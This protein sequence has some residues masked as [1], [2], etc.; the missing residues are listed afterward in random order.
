MAGLIGVDELSGR[1]MKMRNKPPMRQS[2]ARFLNEGGTRL[3]EG[4]GVA[5][6][7]EFMAQGIAEVTRI[8]DMS[9]QDYWREKFVRLGT[10]FREREAHNVLFMAEKV[11]DL[12]GGWVDT[13][14]DSRVR[15]RAMV[16]YEH[17]LTIYVPF[18]AYKYPLSFA[19]PTDIE[20]G[21]WADR[22][23]EACRA[24]LA[25]RDRGLG[26]LRVLLLSVEGGWEEGTC[27]EVT[28]GGYSV[29]SAAVDSLPVEVSEI[30]VIHNNPNACVKISIWEERSVNRGLLVKSIEFHCP[31]YEI[32]RL[33]SKVITYEAS[34]DN[35]G[36]D[37]GASG[38]QKVKVLIAKD[39]ED[40]R[41][42]SRYFLPAQGSECGWP[43]DITLGQIADGRLEPS[44]RRIGEDLTIAQGVGR[45]IL[46]VSYFERPLVSLLWFLGLSFW[47]LYLLEY[48][49]SIIFG[50]G[51]LFLVKRHPLFEG[52]RASWAGWGLSLWPVESNK[53]EGRVKAVEGMD[54][55]ESE[56]R[57]FIFADFSPEHLFLWDPPQWSTPLLNNVGEAEML[58]CKGP[59]TI[60]SDGSYWSWQVAV[61]AG[62]DEN[63]YQY[64]MGFGGA[65]SWLKECDAWCY[66]RRRVFRGTKVRSAEMAQLKGKDA[67]VELLA[68]PPPGPSVDTVSPG[69]SPSPVM[70]VPSSAVLTPWEAV[71]SRV[72]QNVEEV[73]FAV[74]TVCVAFEKMK[75]LFT[76]KCP[77]ASSMILLALLLLAILSLLVPSR[78]VVEA[79][80][81]GYFF[82]GLLV[83]IER[84]RR[85]RQFIDELKQAAK[86]KRQHLR[87]FVSPPVIN[88]WG[89]STRLEDLGCSLLALCGWV[90]DKYQ[91]AI[92]LRT[93]QKLDTILDLIEL[94]ARRCRWFYTQ[95]LHRVC[96]LTS[97]SSHRAAETALLKLLRLQK[98]QLCLPEELIRTTWGYLMPSRCLHFDGKALYVG[99]KNPNNVMVIS[100]SGVL[101]AILETAFG[102]IEIC[103]AESIPGR[104]FVSLVNGDL[105]EI[106]QPLGWVLRSLPRCDGYK[107]GLSAVH[108]GS[109]LIWRRVGFD[110]GLQLLDLDTGQSTTIPFPGEIS[111]VVAR[112]TVE[113]DLSIFTKDVTTGSV[114]EYRG[115]AS[116][117]AKHRVWRKAYLNLVTHMASGSLSDGRFVLLLSIAD[118]IVFFDP[119]VGE[120][121]AVC[122]T[123]LDHSRIDMAGRFVYFASFGD[124]FVFQREVF[125]NP[126]EVEDAS[127]TR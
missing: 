59:R 12:A 17:I 126:L 85:Q 113:G 15:D 2:L 104:A 30:P 38:I 46:A 81:I 26:S 120:A 107:S 61:D 76:W 79:I 13:M 89:P 51:A 3:R 78:Y 122:S 7:G 106:N 43:R 114:T 115:E 67:S 116:G 112:T 87:S 95:D 11:I 10:Q 55:Y 75:N 72:K 92:D 28:H 45:K 16:G 62:T 93:M 117:L 6:L 99:L 8:V 111:L 84:G 40:G 22:I 108:G 109:S 44:F 20:M 36:D 64:A 98:A 57:L 69:L 80:I 54:V 63:G 77:W 9:P 65:S 29:R 121:L 19:F 24:E 88:T 105:L 18:D 49:L 27:L 70:T 97:M 34:E 123:S 37:I 94:V 74:L 32:E 14:P 71:F 68:R 127:L 52:A 42:W 86:S 96:D 125:T 58:P 5:S 23:A 35:D 118:S 39:R 47:A 25:A 110:W 56:R 102:I 100:T 41:S 33:Q 53:V 21:K 50:I 90:S 83:G 101:Q 1:I 82:C 31:V 73:L 124:S 119:A 66:V 103:A 4:S 48:S 60:M 91:V